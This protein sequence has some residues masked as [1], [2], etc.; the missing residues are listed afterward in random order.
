MTDVLD[1]ARLR[2][3]Q[4]D[5]P[6]DIDRVLFNRI[7]AEGPV[8]PVALRSSYPAVLVFESVHRLMAAGRVE[9]LPDGRLQTPEVEG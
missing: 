7:L 5:T 9:Q 3:A 1:E 2:V 6:D 8:A 4:G